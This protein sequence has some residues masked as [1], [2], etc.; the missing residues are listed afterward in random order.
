[1]LGDL[2]GI[3]L[4]LR[5]GLLDGASLRA[6]QTLTTLVRSDP[7]GAPF[8]KLGEQNIPLPSGT[9]WSEGQRVQVTLKQEGTT[10]RIEVAAL[11][12]PAPPTT[13]SAPAGVSALAKL[14]PAL[15]QKLSPSLPVEQAAQLLPA[16]LP[17][18]PGAASPL[19]QLFLGKGTPGPALV[20]LLHWLGQ[21]R[22]AGKLSPATLA[23]IDSLL[24][25]PAPS[26]ESVR[27]SLPALAQSALNEARLAAGHTAPTG[28][29]RSLIA[30]LLDDPALREFLVREGGDKEFDGA[31]R[32]VLARLDTGATANLHGLERGYTFFEIPFAWALG[33]DR[34]QVH[35]FAEAH[36][37]GDTRKPPATVVLD[38]S[39]D[40]LGPLWIHL[41][42]DATTTR[43]DIAAEREETR[44]ALE[45]ER[46]ELTRQLL[47]A[48]L[49][50]PRVYVSAWREAERPERLAALLAP[51]RPLD[52]GA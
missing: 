33:F 36:K 30:A 7:Q 16:Q 22:Q 19:L 28:D 40:S 50:S 38:L 17:P 4:S 20:D 39:L 47:E 13:G 32:Q 43:C 37:Q 26:G 1:M 42:R 5:P 23:S 15:L 21:A 45:A 29:A 11:P 12:N 25:Q 8:I 10:P 27:S 9:P 31:A 46:E 44:A 24:S 35:I 3:S 14:L 52:V 48:G 49:P 6:G 18:T 51:P 2:R 41:Q 34:A